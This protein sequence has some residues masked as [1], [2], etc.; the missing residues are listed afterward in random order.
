MTPC[1]GDDPDLI[2]PT[3]YKRT[4]TGAI[5]EWKISVY[6]NTIVIEWGQIDGAKQTAREVIEKGKNIGRSNE[7]TPSQQAEAEAKSKFE[8]Q[9]K[10][11]YSTDL[12]Q[13]QRGEDTRGG[14]KPMLAHKFEDHGH[15]IKYPCYVQPKADGHRCVAI[16]RSGQVSLWSRNRE[17]IVSMPHIERQLSELFPSVINEDTP[18]DI[19]LDGELFSPDI[20]F[21]KLSGLVRKQEVPQ[22]HELVSYYIF[23]VVEKESFSERIKYLNITELA[24]RNKLLK[25]IK[26]IPTEKVYSEEELLVCFRKY[27]NEGHE[28]LMVRSAGGLYTHD[29]SYDLLKLKEF[30]DAEFKIVDVIEGRGKMKGCALFVCLTDRGH[31]FNCTLNAPLEEQARIYQSKEDWIGK[32]ATIR[33]QGKTETAECL[34]RFPKMLRL[35]EDAN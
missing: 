9:L 15:K 8:K 21:R 7:T 26:I 29:R 32:M 18:V 12:A 2:L 35:R 33:Y 5:Q 4:K 25:N 14:I 34:P 10:D 30:D 28:G 19:I 13:A 20:E 23:D 11:G 27:I 31:R 24:I 1:M 3:L 6:Y 17:R 22:D 16:I